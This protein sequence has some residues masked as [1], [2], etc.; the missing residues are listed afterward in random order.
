MI[1][2]LTEVIEDPGTRP[3]APEPPPFEAQAPPVAEPPPPPPPPEPPP[4]EPAPV[5]TGF[6]EPE[7]AP[8]APAGDDGLDQEA[9][10]GLVQDDLD[11]LL[12][13]LN[14]SP[15]ASPGPPQPEP[16]APNGSW[17]EPAPHQPTAEAD[18]GQDDLD[19]LLR[20]LSGPEGPPPKPA[21]I[22]ERLSSPLDL[23][24]DLDFPEPPPAAGPDEQLFREIV[25]EGASAA[26][27]AVTTPA[28]EGEPDQSDLNE[29]LAQLEEKRSADPEFPADPLP[30][31]VEA[32]AGDSVTQAHLDALLRE[33]EE[34][35]PPSSPVEDGRSVAGDVTDDDLDVLLKEV[36][37]VQVPSEA[38]VIE[39]ELTLPD[40][41]RPEAVL[42]A[43]TIGATPLVL[44]VD[45]GAVAEDPEGARLREA[46]RSVI[47]ELLPQMVRPIIVAEF[48]EIIQ[49][50]KKSSEP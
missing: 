30:V 13:E 18:L 5:E 8:A 12:R 35:S 17:I 29:L 23:S 11:A 36:E 3:S 1:I 22:E 47:E 34:E 9:D 31:E 27:I 46:V 38:E 49:A 14:A 6:A 28:A 37:S 24:Q 4:L 15:G 39:P 42:D 25:P 45:D 2:E 48:Q 10:Q 16:R 33:I 19:T 40:P 20:D 41:D 7:P 32:E 21:E 50:L 26:E 44:G 43:E